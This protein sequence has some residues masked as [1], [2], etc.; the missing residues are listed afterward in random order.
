LQNFAIYNFKIFKSNVKV[1]VELISYK[2]NR[3]DNA[4]VQ[5]I[6][7]SRFDF[8]LMLARRNALNFDIYLPVD[9]FVLI[10]LDLVN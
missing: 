3:L 5:L 4:L 8:L 2:L 6:L 9:A 1:E 10:L 7:V